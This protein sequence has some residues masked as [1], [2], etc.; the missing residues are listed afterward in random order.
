MPSELRAF[1]GWE[2]DHR[3]A[4]GIYVDFEPR[5]NLR[6]SSVATEAEAQRVV[7]RDAKEATELRKIADVARRRWSL[8]GLRKLV[9]E[10]MG[11]AATIG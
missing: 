9:K 1:A 4:F 7:D 10:R 2:L 6:R 8:E 3:E 5:G 11:K